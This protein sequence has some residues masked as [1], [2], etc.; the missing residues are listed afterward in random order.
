MKHTLAAILLLQLLLFACETTPPTDFESAAL[1]G[2]IYSVTNR[3]VPNMAIELDGQRTIRSDIEGRF[4]FTEVK[5]GE[6]TIVAAVDDYEPIT[7]SFGFTDRTQVLHLI[8]VSLSDL[9]KWL[10][11]AIASRNSCCRQGLLG[12]TELFS[13]DLFRH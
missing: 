1:L 13:A 5:K 2:M 6:H 11:E 10:E 8:A 3:P 12:T 7:Y 4:I 9:V